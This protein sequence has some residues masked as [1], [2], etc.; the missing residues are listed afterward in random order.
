MAMRELVEGEC[1]GANPLMKFVSH[2]TQD[3]ALNEAGLRNHVPPS[4][5]HT[6]DRKAFHDATEQ[7]LVG[8]YFHDLQ[9]HYG[10]PQT[11]CM[12]SLLHEIN[13]VESPDLL[14]H[15]MPDDWTDEYLTTTHAG[16]QGWIEE[17]NEDEACVYPGQHA[18]QATFPTKWASEYLEDLRPVEL[19]KEISEELNSKE[20]QDA[21]DSLLDCADDP[22]FANSKVIDAQTG[23]EVKSAE[24]ADRWVDEYE[25]TISSD[26]YNQWLGEYTTGEAHDD[27]G[28]SAVDQ[29]VKADGDFWGKL[30]EEWYH[31]A[32][33]NID[34]H[35]WLAEY[36]SEKTYTFEEDN[37]MMDMPNPFEEGL[38][39][40]KEGDIIS[41][42]LLF[43]AEVQQR[44]DH[45]E[46]W[47]YL[48]TSQSENEQD[49]LAIPAL[50]KC[51]N[52]QPDNLVALMTLAVCYT[53]ES[54]QSQA[55][56]A[57]KLWLSRNPRY[58]GLLT[59]TVTEE[60]SARSPTLKSSMMSNSM[61]NEVREL[62]I[63]AAQLAPENDIDAEV[64]IGLGV[65]FNLSGEYDKA[66]DCFHAALQ[67][68]PHDALVWN[69]LGATLAN[70]GRSEEA[71]DAYR[72]ALELSPGYV[73]ARYNLGISCVN[74]KVFREAVEHFL[75]SLNIQR[76]GARNGRDN[77]STMSESIW[78]T[79]RMSLSLMGKPEFHEA[80]DNRDLDYL[81]EQFN[82]HVIEEPS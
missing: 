70:G 47:Q 69:K 50:N 33:D 48:G 52:L 65:L 37:P 44:P 10:A 57:L 26:E 67:T 27:H 34:D 76:K 49:N 77:T 45:A 41:A 63:K 80:V 39:K 43:E 42:I 12:D 58:S 1:G 54:L 35:P 46:A 73:R 51:L 68:N 22:R 9:H 3:K 31:L 29:T 25:A 21:S 6:Q 7:E 20:L 11:F 55:C 74:L 61:Y 32:R 5:S 28:Q 71:V 56:D 15:A 62:Y 40:L 38:K 18:A 13:H 8:E 23:E 79:L 19:D 24:E 81:N 59:N 30:E 4:S 64:Q 66:V 36:T 82:I 78:T 17:Y 14:H 75:T 53:N 16:A 72:H 60:P 2:Y